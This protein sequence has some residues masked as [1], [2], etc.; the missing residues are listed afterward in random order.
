MQ[1]YIRYLSDIHLE[2]C[3]D[4]VIKSA[5]PYLFLAGDITNVNHKSF[6]K[7]FKYCNSSITL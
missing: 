3:Y 5:A 6:G 7:F 1:H 4:R 2:L